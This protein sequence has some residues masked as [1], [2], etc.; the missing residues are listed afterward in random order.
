MS[1]GNLGVCKELGEVRI[2][3]SSSSTSWAVGVCGRVCV[4]GRGASKF[5][6]KIGSA[7]KAKPKYALVRLASLRQVS[8]QH[9]HAR[10]GGCGRRYRLGL[11]LC[12]TAAL[13][14]SGGGG[15]CVLA[16]ANSGAIP[17]RL[18]G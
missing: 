12:A 17:G 18:L 4:V 7:G 8:F 3:A 10:D 5:R 1:V 15:S 11:C 6:I 2:S 9:P 16:A 13:G 14:C